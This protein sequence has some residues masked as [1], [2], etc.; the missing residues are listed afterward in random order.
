MTAGSYKQ[1]APVKTNLNYN[2]LAGISV[3][4][5]AFV[6]VVGSITYPYVFVN[7]FFEFF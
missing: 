2:N 1:L 3:P 6:F 5:K 7:S 4:L